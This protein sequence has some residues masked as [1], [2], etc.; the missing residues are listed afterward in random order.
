MVFKFFRRFRKK[1]KVP[2]YYAFTIHTTSTGKDVLSYGALLNDQ[3]ETAQRIKVKKVQ[4]EQVRIDKLQEEK[5]KEEKSKRQI[6][7]AAYDPYNNRDP[8]TGCILFDEYES[9]DPNTLSVDELRTL[10][11]YTDMAMCEFFSDY[12]T[13]VFEIDPNTLVTLRPLLQEYRTIS[14]NM[15]ASIMNGGSA[16]DKRLRKF[17]KRCIAYLWPMKENVK[18]KIISLAP[19]PPS[20]KI[21]AKDPIGSQYAKIYYDRKSSRLINFLESSSL[22]AQYSEL[23]SKKKKISKKISSSKRRSSRDGRK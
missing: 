3:V 23:L 8:H 16:D 14:D 13:R 12:K 22:N 1:S 15:K 17:N 7:P 4:V 10:I 11:C 21:L 9:R 2:Q 6:K 18:E 19:K 5:R 20:S